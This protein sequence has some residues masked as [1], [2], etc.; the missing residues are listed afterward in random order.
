MTASVILWPLHTN[1]PKLAFFKKKNCYTNTFFL[2]L[3]SAIFLTIFKRTMC[4]LVNPKKYFQKKFN[5]QLFYLPIVS[6]TFILSWATT[7][8]NLFSELPRAVRLLKTSCFGKI[9]VCVIEKMLATLQLF[10][11][12]KARREVNQHIKHKSR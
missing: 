1:L 7:F 2:K 10:Q 9:T 6:R 11:T 3:V 8:T 4:F 5:L 12:I